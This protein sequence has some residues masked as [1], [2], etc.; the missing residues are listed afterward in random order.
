M[1]YTKTI[2]GH[3]TFYID[4]YK[5]DGKNLY[6]I[7][8]DEINVNKIPE[9]VLSRLNELK[10][11]ESLSFDVYLEYPIDDGNLTGTPKI[12]SIYVPTTDYESDNAVDIESEDLSEEFISIL[13]DMLIV[14]SE[15]GDLFEEL[16][17]QQE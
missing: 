15:D 2:D 6:Y 8:E 1:G 4:I 12:D 16:L 11:K 17:E 10:E 3:T 5:E 7:D 13:V 9:G 14:S